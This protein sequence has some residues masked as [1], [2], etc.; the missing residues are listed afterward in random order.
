MYKNKTFLAI[1]P[2][3]GGSK[4]LPRKNILDFAGKPLIA[5]T[6]EAALK[7]GYLDRVVVTSDSDEILEI[8]SL[9]GAETIER[10][11]RLAED[12]S[13]TFD[14]VA[15]A[16][17]RVEEP[18]D[19]VVLLQP[20][21]PLRESRHI[22]EAIELLELKKADGVISVCETDHPPQWSNT[23][24]PD[25][26]LSDFLSEELLGKRSQEFGKYYRLNGA[27][28]ICD[29]QKLLEEGSFF[30]KSGIYA[31]R[32]EKRHSIDIDDYYDYLVAKALVGG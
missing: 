6:I 31:Y 17:S 20:T 21:S 5:W 28:Y 9:Y 14:A 4:R 30:L 1:V 2:A 32:M 24:P 11:S 29:T 15:D 3:R 10:P 7:S 16:I 12:D 23:L 26:S 22:D 27:I 13:S 8:S 19:Y 25:D 18:Y